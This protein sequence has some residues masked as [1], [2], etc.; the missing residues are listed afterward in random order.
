MQ[1]TWYSFTLTMNAITFP[2][3]SFYKAKNDFL[4]LL[5]T[6]FRCTYLQIESYFLII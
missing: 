5:R 3:E 4:K 1:Q 2:K 6:L